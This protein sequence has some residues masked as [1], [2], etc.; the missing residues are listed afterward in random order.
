MTATL[1]RD[2]WTRE[3]RLAAPELAPLL[4]Q[5]PTVGSCRVVRVAWRRG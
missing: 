5:A 3:W 1:L 2:R 4:R